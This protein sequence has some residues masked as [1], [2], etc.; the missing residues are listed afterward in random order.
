[1]PGCIPPFKLKVKCHSWQKSAWKDRGILIE[2]CNN[3]VIT[4]LLNQTVFCYGRW[5]SVTLWGSTVFLLH[6]VN[7]LSHTRPQKGQESICNWHCRRA[8]RFFKTAHMSNMWPRL[9]FSWYSV[10]LIYSKCAHSTLTLNLLPPLSRCLSNGLLLFWE[11]VP[12]SVPDLLYSRLLGLLAPRAAV[13]GDL[14][15]ARSVTFVFVFSLLRLHNKLNHPLWKH[16]IHEE[17]A[18]KGGDVLTE[19]HSALSRDTHL[20]CAAFLPIFP[21]W[22]IYFCVFST[23]ISFVSVLQGAAQPVLW[24][25]IDGVTGYTR[26]TSVTR[27]SWWF[28]EEK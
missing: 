22:R 24:S 28:G 16:E 20:S 26:V 18:H 13:S 5:D 25:W 15:H 23:D 17:G 27:A 1:M 2:W 4:N 6:E 3:C 14:G 9:N 19:Q 7:I 21:N 12:R 10:T 11:A 8:G